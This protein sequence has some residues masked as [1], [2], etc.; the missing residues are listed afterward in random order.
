MGHV[1]ESYWSGD[2]LWSIEALEQQHRRTGEH[3][4][5]RPDHCPLVIDETEVPRAA[6]GDMAIRLNEHGIIESGELSVTAKLQLRVKADVLHLC[7]VAGGGEGLGGQRRRRHRTRGPQVHQDVRVVGVAGTPHVQ[8]GIE[9][10]DTEAN[11]AGYAIGCLP[12]VAQRPLSVQLDTEDD[13]AVPQQTVEM[14]TLRRSRPVPATASP[15]STASTPRSLR[16][17][18][19]TPINLIARALDE[20]ERP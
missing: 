2:L 13:A 11:D 1:C 18:S 17:V 20:E 16:A 14:E 7:V 8:R 19:S 12:D 10:S 15:C 5:V 6:L 4:G 3:G 9:D